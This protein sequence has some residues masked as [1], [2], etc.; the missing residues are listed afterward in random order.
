LACRQRRFDALLVREPVPEM[1]LEDFLDGLRVAS[2]ASN[3]AFVQ[4]LAEQERVAE[5]SPLANERFGISHW[6]DFGSL[7]AF[8]AKNVLGVAP[9]LS[10]RFMAEVNTQ[11]AGGTLSRFCQVENI[12]DSGLLI[13]TKAALPIGERVIMSFSLPGVSQPVRVS[14][15]VVRHTDP[16]EIEGFAVRFDE[17][18]GVSFRRLRDF[19][20]SG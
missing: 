13:K 14:G 11:L 18:A 12:S 16:S 20:S 15:D 10:E 2:G 3:R 6:A 9:R 5:L 19:L 8:I 4:V 1:A 17:F 7:L